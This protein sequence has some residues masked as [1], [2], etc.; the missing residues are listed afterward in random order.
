MPRRSGDKFFQE[1]HRLFIQPVRFSQPGTRTRIARFCRS[2]RLHRL[3]RD[4]TLLENVAIIRFQSFERSVTKPQGDQE[5][6]RSGHDP[7]IR[8]P[9]DAEEKHILIDPNQVTEGIRDRS[10]GEELPAS[11]P[12][13]YTIGIK[14]IAIEVKTV[15]MSRMSRKKV[16][17]LKAQT[18]G[19]SPTRDAKPVRTEGTAASNSVRPLSLVKDDERESRQVR[20]RCGYG[21]CYRKHLN[22]K[23]DLFD[24]IGVRDQGT[25][26]S[27]Q[28][29]LRHQPWNKPSENI[30]RKIARKITSRSRSASQD[31]PKNQ[32]IGPDNHERVNV[33]PPGPKPMQR[34]GNAQIPIDHFAQQFSV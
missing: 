16:S 18:K 8:V 5:R 6:H 20:N 2:R 7:R 9:N 23:N 10:T 19:R 17:V 28:R 27:N 31:E 33:N 11:S 1:I 4:C 29:G 22:W 15:T 34:M 12:A 24:Q 14:Y 25:R 3:G 26:A 13:R 32:K 21:R 30:G